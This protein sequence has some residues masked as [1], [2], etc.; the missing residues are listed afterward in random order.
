MNITHIWL[1]LTDEKAAKL[2]ISQQS[3][4]LC[5]MSQSLA[6]TI[7]LCMGVSFMVV[8]CELERSFVFIIAFTAR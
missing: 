1:H 5:A 2:N 4:Y 6:T 7:A 3:M 8:K